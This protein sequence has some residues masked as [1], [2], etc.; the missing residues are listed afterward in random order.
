MKGDPL[1]Q[2]NHERLALGQVARDLL[3]LEI[4]LFDT[5]HYVSD[6]PI[7]FC[8]QLTQTKPVV[9]HAHV[10]GV[11]QVLKLSPKLTSLVLECFVR[12]ILEQGAVVE[13]LED[14]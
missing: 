8:S 6:A 11:E 7:R 14:A 1:L 3:V 10:D 12:E 9:H 2:P 13:R 4:L 5:L